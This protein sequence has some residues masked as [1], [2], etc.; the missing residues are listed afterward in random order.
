[1]RDDMEDVL[2]KF[3]NEAEWKADNNTR[4]KGY[5]FDSSGVCHSGSNLAMLFNNISTPDELAQL[6][7]ELN[8]LFCVV[9]NSSFGFF[10]VTDRI[11]SIPLFYTI[12][13][14]QLVVT[15]NPYKLVSNPVWEEQSNLEFKTAGYTLGG[16][17]LYK[18]VS[19]VEAASFIC[20]K[21]NH[22]SVIEYFNYTSKQLEHIDYFVAKKELKEVLDRSM[23]RM[24]KSI[25]GR[26]IAIPLSGGYDSRFILAWL[27]MNGYSNVFAFTYGRKG[28]PDILLAE[29]VAK[30][31]NTPWICLPYN[32]IISQLTEDSSLEDYVLYASCAS[33]MPF[34]QDYPAI[35]NIHERN[36]IPFDSV[37]VPGHSG[38][39]IAGSHLM[40][41]DNVKTSLSLVNNIFGVH[42]SYYRVSKA[43][44]KQVLEK[45]DEFFNNYPQCTLYSVKEWW[46]FKERQAKFIVNSCKAYQFFG[47]GIRLPFFDAELIAF[48]RTV[49]FDFKLY[50]KLYNEVLEDAYFKP[51]GIY[52]ADELQPTQFDYQKKFVK[53]YIKNIFPFLMYFAKRIDSLCYKEIA[54][55]L[56]EKYKYTP[57]S[58]YR[59]GL[60]SSS[61]IDWYLNFI[62][63]KLA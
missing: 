34:F 24:L 38:D 45:I 15:D 41:K 4:A 51:L 18:G 63:K 23:Q 30:K 11:R 46:D 44:K 1:M 13:L 28:N 50:K 32:D 25:E 8:G 42:H 37:I 36:L 39:F 17:T 10:A 27:K 9:G 21:N 43:E 48:F 22:V 7:R 31:L 52:F 3:E 55:L 53:E 59:K 29:K 35:K 26:P 56:F 49:P 60:L 12:K 19:Q 40:P 58:L 47:Y 61:I 33:S 20:Y 5:A 14:D 57:D 62:R 54:D 16:T 6:A 2:F